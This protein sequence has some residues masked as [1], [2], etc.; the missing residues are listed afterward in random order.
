[1]TFPTYLGKVPPMGLY[2]RD[3]TDQ[4]TATR[5]ALRDSLQKRLTQPTSLDHNGTSAQ[6][7]QR[8]ADI[9]RELRDIDT[10]LDRRDG[11]PAQNRPFYVTG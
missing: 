8:T 7:N 10:E 9:K 4:L 3:T 5:A 1:M 6:Y 2:S 11:L